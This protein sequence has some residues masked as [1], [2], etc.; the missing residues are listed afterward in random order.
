VLDREVFYTFQGLTDDGHFYVAAF[1][2]VETGIFPEEPPACTQ[3]AD[4]NYD[5]VAEWTR[6]LSDQLTQLNAQAEDQFAPSLT[7]L[8]NLIESIQIGQP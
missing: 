3:C 2:P 8:D 6:V 7:V 4:P 1:F 5:P